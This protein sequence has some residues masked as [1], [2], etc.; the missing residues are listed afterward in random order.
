MRPAKLRGKIPTAVV[1]LRDA[2]VKGVELCAASGRN[3]F[4][5]QILS[6]EVAAGLRQ[7]GLRSCTGRLQHF[8]ISS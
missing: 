1:A 5:G 2:I 3:V 8:L 6:I 4:D 7:R